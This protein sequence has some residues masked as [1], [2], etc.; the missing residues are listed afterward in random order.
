[1]TDSWRPGDIIAWRGIYRN[2]VWHAMPTFVVRDTGKEVVVALTPGTNGL[3]EENYPSGDKNRK[4]RWDFKNEDWKLANFTWHTNRLLLILEP[5]KYYS[6]NFFWNHERNEFLGYYIN[7]QL[8]FRR[9]DCSID[10]LA[11]ELDIDVKPDLSI[12]WKD[13]DDYERGIETG[14]ILPA[15]V[16]GIEAAKSEILAKLEKRQ[17]PFDGS[18][19]E[20]QPD[21]NWLPP[22]LPENW[23]KI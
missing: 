23:D 8:P 20:W 10:T 13:I 5:E 12:E 16:E 4:R 15:W 7:F 3:V 17:Y 6:T 22:Q 19:L 11:L 1:M 9:S 18:W 14:V 2:R 21:P